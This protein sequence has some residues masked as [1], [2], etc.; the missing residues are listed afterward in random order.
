MAKNSPTT[1]LKRDVFLKRF[2]IIITALAGAYLLAC[3]A[4]YFMQKSMLFPAQ[5]TQIVPAD[6]QPTAGDSASQAFI[7]GNC[8]KL[9]VAHWQIKNAKGTLMMNHGNGESLASINDYAYAFHALGYNLMTWDY[10]GYGQSTDC[11]FSQA[12]L[13]DDAER[14]YQWLAAQEKPEKIF[15]FGYSLGSG[16][17]L[18]VAAQHPQNPVFLVAAYDSLLDIAK[19]KM[20]PLVPVSF[21]MRYPMQTQ[22]WIAAI[23]QPIYVIHGTQDQLIAPQRAQALVQ[24]SQAKINIEWVQNAGHTDDALFLYRNQ[25]LKKLLP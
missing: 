24:K 11:W 21:L 13:L 6:W 9:H 2:R 18:S 20:P 10:P 4:L 15:I 1:Y 14:A 8:G 12:E 19:Q 3:G 25:W 22:T 7:N 17:A 23:K 5:Y 16:V